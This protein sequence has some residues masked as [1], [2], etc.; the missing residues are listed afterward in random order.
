VPRA[1]VQ[2][3]PSYRGELNSLG[4][5][6]VARLC[7]PALIADALRDKAIEKI[8]W[9]QCERYRTSCSAQIGQ[10]FKQRN[11]S[12]RRLPTMRRIVVC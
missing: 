2:S 3:E 1:K 7:T 8:V 12:F 10:D 4:F 11:L 6:V 5:E 9:N